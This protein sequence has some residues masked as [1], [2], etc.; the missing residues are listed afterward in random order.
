M[1][2]RTKSIRIASTLLCSMALGMWIGAGWHASVHQLEDLT[3][4]CARCCCYHDK[5]QPRIEAADHHECPICQIGMMAPDVQAAV[6]FV[7]IPESAVHVLPTWAVKRIARPA[8]IGLP[9]QRGP[10]CLG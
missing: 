1:G 7:L 10:P 3:E 6:A 2:T 5:N 8:I 9:L 4:D